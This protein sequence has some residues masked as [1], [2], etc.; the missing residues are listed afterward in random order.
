MRA[1]HGIRNGELATSPLGNCPQV[2][3]SSAH[4]RHHRRPG[5]R[6]PRPPVWL[7][8]SSHGGRILVLVV[9]AAGAAPLA[10]L[11]PLLLRP[12]RAA[13]WSKCT[14]GRA[15]ARLL[16]LLRARLAAPARHAQGEAGLLGAPLPRVLER[17]ASKAADSTAFD[18]SGLRGDPQPSG[19][20]LLRLRLPHAAARTDDL[21]Q[22]PVQPAAAV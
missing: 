2:L 1:A 3:V 13:A 8:S 10:L 15:P 14:L 22:R 6:K 17:A 7:S 5:P 18:H 16:C 20:A 12:H 19:R 11:V 21:Q 9:A 4:G